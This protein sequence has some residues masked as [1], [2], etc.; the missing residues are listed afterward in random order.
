MKRYKS[1]CQAQRFLSA[2]DQINTICDRP[3]HLSVISYCHAPADA[4]GLWADYT[5]ELIA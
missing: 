5:V 4:F 3:T 2:H 1:H